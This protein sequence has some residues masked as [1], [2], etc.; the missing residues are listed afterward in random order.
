MAVPNRPTIT[1]S[2][3]RATLVDLASSAYSAPASLLLDTHTDASAAYSLRHL[4]TAYAGSCIRVRRSS[5]NVEANIGFAS[6][7]L[8][9]TALAAHV[10]SASGF[11]VTWYDQSTHGRNVTMATAATQ[12]R[13]V[14][15]GALDTDGS[16][17]AMV[18]SGAQRL[19]NGTLLAYA[20]GSGYWSAFA[21][22]KLSVTGIQSILD[23][24]NGGGTTRVAQCIR[25]NAGTAEAIAFNAA[26]SAFTDAGAA[27][28]GTRH[29]FSSVRAAT[30]V[31]IWVDSASA[32]SSATTGT[33]RSAASP[34][35][36][37]SL[38]SPSGLQ[39]LVGTMQEA[40][41]FAGDKSSDRAAIDAHQKAYWGTP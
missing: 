35:A 32:S 9:L 19:F 16:L 18:F 34:L 31:E 40:I 25:T 41:L 17:G 12:P 23:I 15:A 10:G 24:D 26:G 37:G 28:G 27:T 4:R 7:F 20:D 14:N 6:G 30:T 29:Q 8:N 3:I 36:I 39:W 21:V 5:D 11:V 1:V 38:A 33:P 22:G 13:I 2:N